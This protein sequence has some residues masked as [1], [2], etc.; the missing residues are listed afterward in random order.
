MDRVAYDR[1]WGF[2]LALTCVT[3]LRV[4]DRAYLWHVIADETSAAVIAWLVLGSLAG[5]VALALGVSGMRSRWRH[6]VN[7]LSG[8]VV[9]ALPIVAPRI[10]TSHPEANPAMLPLGG[11]STV[12]WVMLVALGALYAGSGIR[13]VRRNQTLGQGMGGL[14]AFLLL[15]FAF[16]PTEVVGGSPYAVERIRLFADPGAHWRQIVPF[17]IVSAGVVC[18]IVNLVRTPF[19]I[20][21]AKLTRVLL[22]AGLI[23]WIMLPFLERDADLAEH[24]PVAWGAV[25]FLAPLFLAVDGSIAFIAISVTRDAT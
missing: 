17:C 3:P 5:L 4:G 23:F 18:G 8:M 16:L 12:G 14:G 25:R 22:I 20:M 9:L 15:L 10:W 21:L 1:N 7:L 13:I 11:L 24:L 2:L 6:F 19:E